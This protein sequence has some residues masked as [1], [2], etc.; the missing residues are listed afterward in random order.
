MLVPNL[1]MISK[2]ELAVRAE[3]AS[4]ITDNSKQ[5]SSEKEDSCFLGYELLFLGINELEE[6]QE[7]DF[8]GHASRTEE[9]DNGSLP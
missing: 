4:Q 7:G 6:F 5:T 2:V 9:E 8:V 1:K 3:H